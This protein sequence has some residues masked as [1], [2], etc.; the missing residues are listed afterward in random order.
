MTT[1]E[2]AIKSGNGRLEFVW[3]VRGMPWAVTTSKEFATY[4]SSATTERRA[5]FGSDTYNAGANYFA[6]EV[7]VWPLLEPPGPQTITNDDAMSALTGGT[8]TAKISD[9]PQ[10]GASIWPH[11][12][13]T[14]CVGLEGLQSLANPRIDRTIISARLGSALPKT[15]TGLS[16]IDDSGSLLGTE[17]AAASD[18]D[19]LV[20][21]IGSE[22]MAITDGTTTS[23][24]GTGKATYRGILGT[25]EQFHAPNRTLTG[26]PSLRIAN[27]PLNGIQSRPYA[28]YAFVYLPGSRADTVIGPAM[29]RHGKVSSNINYSNGMWSIEC[30]PWWSWLDTDLTVP[31][32][33]AP[34][35]KYVLTRYGS[36]AFL[37]DYFPGFYDAH[38]KNF[39]A[40]NPPHVVF[41]EY[42]SATDTTSPDMTVWLC[43][44]WES[45]TYDTVEDLENDICSE[46]TTASAADGFS[47]TYTRTPGGPACADLVDGDMCKI[48]GDLAV[49]LQWGDYYRL[50]TQFFPD[51]ADYPGLITGGFIYG[52]VAFDPPLFQPYWVA[53]FFPYK[54]LWPFSA[55]PWIDFPVV[56]GPGVAASMCSSWLSK[57][58]WYTDEVNFPGVY[59]DVYSFNNMIESPWRQKPSYIV[60]WG[61]TKMTMPAPSDNKQLARVGYFPVPI[62]PVA[63]EARLWVREDY[64]IQ[65]LT[66]GSLMNLGTDDPE[67]PIL[68]YDS[69]AINDLL[70]LELPSFSGWT[71][72]GQFEVD[73]VGL[74]P[75]GN[76][77]IVVGDLYET[78]DGEPTVVGIDTGDFDPN[79]KKY[80]VGQALI[81]YDQDSQ[82]PLVPYDYW[83]LSQ[84]FILEGD[85][86]SEVFLAVLGHPGAGPTI[87]EAIQADH[88]P[89]Y[90]TIDWDLLDT[91]TSRRSQSIVS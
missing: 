66:A 38:K 69:T 31:A 43:D 40:R 87:A 3:H 34:M 73:D 35:A 81:G 23:T 88:I 42:D 64:S 51:P 44:E 58:N 30:L 22:C 72:L 85:T 65:S 71:S 29:V 45:V 77:Y 6:D 53:P 50:P 24:T 60:Q 84:S 36:D 56:Y 12:A 17:C 76:N 15:E 75:V 21:W 59:H 63:S 55:G 2:E 90:E 4:L 37:D 8:W 26:A 74:G 14:S 57:V 82:S 10:T 79:N 5:M 27:A 9:I 61:W 25:V 47:R 80:I 28:L 62:D 83:P 32:A 70:G 78:W 18:A 1:F 16:F 54:P 11:S 68:S 89:D 86:L 46:M 41:R 48:W 52:K 19:P 7:D 49:I 39:I 67:H 20:L 33:N 91:M 13:R